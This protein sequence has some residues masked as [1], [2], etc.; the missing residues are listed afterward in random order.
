MK[1]WIFSV[2][3]ASFASAALADSHETSKLHS[4]SASLTVSATVVS[5]EPPLETHEV[6]VFQMDDGSKVAVTYRV[7]LY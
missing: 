7:I 5:N 6:I 4:A 1:F 2:L 3:L